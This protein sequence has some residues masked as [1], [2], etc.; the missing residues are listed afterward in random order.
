MGLD[1][2]AT[3]WRRRLLQVPLLGRLYHHA[4]HCIVT[5]GFRNIPNPSAQLI[6]SSM[7]VSFPGTDRWRGNECQENDAGRA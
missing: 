2:P 7:Y 6:S 3:G 1:R 4:V 5:V